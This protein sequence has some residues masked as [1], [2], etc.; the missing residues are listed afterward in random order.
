[1]S[2]YKAKV[3]PM[4]YNEGDHFPEEKKNCGLHQHMCQREVLPSSC[5]PHAQEVVFH[6]HFS[7]FFLFS[8]L[9]FSFF[10]IGT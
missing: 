5:V 2:V 6:S 9:F 4:N 3:T 8:S 10:L 7:F 1:V